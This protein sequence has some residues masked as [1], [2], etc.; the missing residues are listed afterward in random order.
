MKIILLKI[1]YLNLLLNQKK[2]IVIKRA[3]DKILKIIETL[4]LKNLE[5][6]TIILNSDNLEK[7]SKVKIFF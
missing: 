7:K 5:D 6:T 1:F 3:T 2:F 4:H